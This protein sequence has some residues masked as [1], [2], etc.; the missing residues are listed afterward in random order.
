MD[1]CELRERD[2]P[3][4]SG[5]EFL[6][7]T[8]ASFVMP[9]DEFTQKLETL[10]D[11]LKERRTSL[12]RVSPRL[13]VSS[14]DLDLPAYLA[15]IEGAGCLV[16]MDDLNTGSR[17]FWQKVDNSSEP[18]YALAKRILTKPAC[19]RMFDWERYV[20]RLIKWVREYNIDGVLD[21]PAIHSYWRGLIGP[22][23]HDRLEEVGIPE[24]SFTREYHLSNVA[25]LRTRV[26]AFLE[27]L[28]R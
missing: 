20:E 22:Y 18:L 6:A 7:L 4:L 17:Y 24:M 8:T 25:Q 14:E 19:P 2:V 13:L 11:Y 5:S 15:L 16:A 23:L 1:L 12:P 28:N 21:F 27:I 9:K 3:P 10:F 26:G